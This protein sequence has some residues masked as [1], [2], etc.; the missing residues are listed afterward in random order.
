MPWQRGTAEMTTPFL[1]YL[2]WKDSSPRRCPPAQNHA[3]GG[4][5]PSDRRSSL[6]GWWSNMRLRAPSGRPAY[7]GV[8]TAGGVGW[9]R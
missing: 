4:G 2:L 3:V 1:W 6:M 5:L 7:V 9:G 8:G